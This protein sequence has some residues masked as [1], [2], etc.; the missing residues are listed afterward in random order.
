[1]SDLD[2]RLEKLRNVLLSDQHDR[3][4]KV[5][6]LERVMELREDPRAV[7]VIREATKAPV[8]EPMLQHFVRVLG[9]LGDAGALEDLAGYIAHPRKIV[10]VNAVKAAISYDPE[11]AVQMVMKVVRSA[12]LKN[13][14]AAVKLLAERCPREA[15]PAVERLIGSRSR[16]DRLVAVM[17]LTHAVDLDAVRRLIDLIRTE[18]EPALFELAFRALEQQATREHRPLIDQLVTDLRGRADRLRDLA[19]RLPEHAAERAAAPQSESRRLP[20]PP[21][22]TPSDSRPELVRAP[23]TRAHKLLPWQEKERKVKARR[24]K[25][26]KGDAAEASR[27]SQTLIGAALA[28]GL[29]MTFYLA[30]LRNTPAAATG[31]RR[32]EDIATSSLGAVNAKVKIVGTIA[33]VH[34]DYNTM[35][36]R[37]KD[38]TLASV[39]FKDSIASFS[40]GRGVEVDG[41]IREV[42]AGGVCVVDG[43]TAR[44]L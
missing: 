8:N 34:A 21:P 5:R 24:S 42:R 39:S 16:R 11:H 18:G 2:A 40:A 31:A 36:V 12:P 23:D 28:I 20:L 43:I 15:G 13:V 27:W 35:L 37:A 38:G 9:Y 32:V 10:A 14:Q 4:K 22:P 25:K 3:K 41:T 1:M 26:D 44:L 19:G 6:V 29:A 33:E 7:A 17:F 30:G